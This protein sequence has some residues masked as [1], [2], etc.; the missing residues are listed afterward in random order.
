MGLLQRFVNGG[1]EADGCP[2]RDRL[3]LIPRVVNV[4]EWATTA[5]LSGTVRGNK[6]PLYP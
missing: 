4:D 2:T 3:K 1:K 6:Q 5:P